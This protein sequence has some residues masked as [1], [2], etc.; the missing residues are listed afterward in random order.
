MN[1]PIVEVA[2]Q[3]TRIDSSVEGIPA[4]VYVVKRPPGGVRFRA[5]SS[6][7]TASVE[8]TAVTVELTA[9]PR[10]TTAAADTAVAAEPR[11]IRSSR[12]GDQGDRGGREAT[13]YDFLVKK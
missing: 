2:H 12:A 10:G 13:H 7:V 4:I 5:G 6:D 9:A 11:L 1:T 8:T 3:G